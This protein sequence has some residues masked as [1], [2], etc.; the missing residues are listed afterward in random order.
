MRAIWIEIVQH[1]RE[2]PARRAEKAEIEA[3]G[4]G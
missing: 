2:A 3:Q 4:T 1:W